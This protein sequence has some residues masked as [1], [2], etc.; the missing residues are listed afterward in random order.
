MTLMSL[1]RPSGRPFTVDIRDA[2]GGAI[3]DRRLGILDGRYARGRGPA[4]EL[5]ESR[6]RC[7]STPLR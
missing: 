3:P 6:P 7:V 2:G 5:P 1:R 4:C